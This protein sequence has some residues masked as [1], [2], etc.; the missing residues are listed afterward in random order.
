MNMMLDP[1]DLGTARGIV[2][3]GFELAKLLS[4][5]KPETARI[6]DAIGPRS[7]I[8]N[9]KG[10]A[11][12]MNRMIRELGSC[13]VAIASSDKPAEIIATYWVSSGEDFDL[14]FARVFGERHAI[15][16][17]TFT[18]GRLTKHAAIRFIQRAEGNIIPA[19]TV[20][21]AFRAATLATNVRA[22]GEFVS[23]PADAAVLVPA[24]FGLAAVV[25][26][27]DSTVI[28]F[29]RLDR[30]G[31]QRQDVIDGVAPDGFERS[32]FT[33]GTYDPSLLTPEQ[34]MKIVSSADVLRRTKEFAA[35]LE[36]REF[37]RTTP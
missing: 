16:I 2:R 19:D 37:V 26:A 9:Q 8:F 14:C 17:N 30:L 27:A 5:R 20:W 1:K 25:L 33:L 18:V 32:G 15:C 23:L 6:N 4:D 12:I 21:A 29:V 22:M 28:T 10:R 36:T 7:S 31:P 35:S 11:R 24:G 34:R 13:G 3:R